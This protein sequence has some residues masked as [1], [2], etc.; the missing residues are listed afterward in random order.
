MSL[1]PFTP[2]SLER[3]EDRTRSPREPRIRSREEIAN[4]NRIEAIDPE[5]EEVDLDEIIPPMLPPQ[6]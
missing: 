1:S 3:G 6:R 5:V 2:T 4:D